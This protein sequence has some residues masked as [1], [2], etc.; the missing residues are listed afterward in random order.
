MISSE[1]AA[2]ETYYPGFDLE[3]V[4]AGKYGDSI[5]DGV[6]EPFSYFSVDSALTDLNL[7]FA[8]LQR[9]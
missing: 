9:S 4:E 2:P 7:L 8:T 6:I 5:H 1:W 3:D